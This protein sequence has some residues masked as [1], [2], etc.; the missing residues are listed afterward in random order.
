MLVC[1]IH[2]EGEKSHYLLGDAD[3]AMST[4]DN[5]LSWEGGVGERGLG[6]ECG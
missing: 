1:V 4:G 6:E 3:G 5:E 2:N